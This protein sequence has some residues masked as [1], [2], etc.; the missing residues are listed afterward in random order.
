V[1]YVDHSKS[2]PTD[3]KLYLKGAWSL[4]RDVISNFWKISD[5]ISKR[6]QYSLIVCIKFE[7]EVVCAVSNGYV[8]SDL[9]HWVTPKS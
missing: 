8:G 5:D 1:L 4:S 6:V 3:D 2:Q 7:Y 9:G